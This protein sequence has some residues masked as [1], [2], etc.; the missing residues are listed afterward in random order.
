MSDHDR[1]LSPGFPEAASPLRPPPRPV[2]FRLRCQLLGGYA[3]LFS[4]AVFALTL[5]LGVPLLGGTDPLAFWRFAWGV[6]EAPGWLEGSREIRYSE[7]DHRI[8]RHDYRFRL[9]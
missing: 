4:S 1:C 7:N 8:Y 5:A 3:V 9:P 2:P 6:S